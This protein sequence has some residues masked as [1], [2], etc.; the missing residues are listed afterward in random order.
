[1]RLELL[2]VNHRLPLLF[3]RVDQREGQMGQTLFH[4]H[5]RCCIEEEGGGEAI[6]R[7]ILHT[8]CIEGEEV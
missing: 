7:E 2:R 1:M 6:K 8:V 4:C 5:C 3:T